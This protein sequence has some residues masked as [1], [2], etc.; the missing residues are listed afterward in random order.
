MSKTT[1]LKHGDNPLISSTY[2]VSRIGVR[3]AVCQHGADLLVA[4][5]S[6]IHQGCHLFLTTT[7]VDAGEK[8]EDLRVL[9]N[10]L[11]DQLTSSVALGS[12][13]RSAS[14]AQTSWWPP[15]AAYIKAVVPPLKD[16][17]EDER[18][19]SGISLIIGAIKPLMKTK[20]LY[21]FDSI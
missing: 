21:S 15:S 8:R 17:I 10:R 2:P 7:K 9:L 5:F 1:G 20:F 13:P 12:A 3:P 11:F 14:Q 16:R 6:S 18:Q 4:P 19:R